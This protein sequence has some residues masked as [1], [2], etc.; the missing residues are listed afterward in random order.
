MNLKFGRAICNNLSTAESREWLVTNGIGG[1]AS[2]TIAGIL[3][4]RYHGLLVGALKPPVARH[5]LLTKIDETV[6]YNEQYYDLASNRWVDGT[7]APQG[8]TNIESFHLEGTM[9]VWNF[10]FADGLLE[11]RIWMEQGENTTYIQYKYQ[12]GS[13]PL[14]L[15]LKAL[16]NYRDYHSKTDGKAVFYINQY[17]DKSLEIKA[18]TDAK[19]LYLSTSGNNKNNNFTWSIKNSW[20][21]DFALAVEKYRGLDDVEDHLLAATGNVILQPGDVLTITASTEKAKTVAS[22]GNSEEQYRRKQELIELFYAQNKWQAAPEWIEQLVLAADQFI[23]DRPLPDNPEGKTIIAGYPWFTDWGR[24]TMIALPGL[25][26]ATGRFAI[27]KTI[28]HTFAKYVDQGMLPNVFPDAGEIPHY[29]TADAT[30]WYFEAIRAYYCATEDQEFLAELF[31]LLAEIIDWHLKGTRY[32]IKMDDDGLLFAGES[33]VQLTWM[34][35]KVGDWVV[36]PRIGK[37]IEL[38]A[39]WYNALVCMDYFS[40]IL[41]KSEN[42]YQEIAAKT[43]SHFSKFWYEAGGYCYDVIDSPEGNDSSFRPNQIFAVSLPAIGLGT[44]RTG[45]YQTGEFQMGECHSPLRA[46]Q[47]KM[48]VDKIG[49]RLLT[50]SGLRSLSP[51]DQNYI[52]TYGGNQLQRDGSYHQ[53]TTWGWLICHFVQAHLQVYNNPEL[54]RSF[55]EP[56]ANHLHDACIGSIS[57]IFDG[58]IPCTPRGCFAQAWSVAEVLRTWLLTL[59]IEH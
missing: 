58:D 44:S 13:Q 19:S 53:G 4:R 43:R 41:G 35:A 24:D 27:A 23:V 30:L 36:T 33:G 57:E 46:S 17:Q 37:P 18:F 47:Q 40:G 50:S 22:I 12:R 14:T 11:K 38:N 56:M 29:N 3:T 31:P 2:G 42:Q 1:Y 45:E 10:A 9:P 49:Q 21:R 34:D 55:L 48:V 32:N 52:G 5:L 6:S 59:D 26:I 54:A 7:V 8:Y 25:T 20:Y 16:V 15:F 51:E 28:L 39:L